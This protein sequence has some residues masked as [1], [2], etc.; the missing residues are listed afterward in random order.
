MRTRKREN[1]LKIEPTISM[2]TEEVFRVSIKTS[3]IP[4]QTQTQGK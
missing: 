4:A 1:T 2:I 3:A